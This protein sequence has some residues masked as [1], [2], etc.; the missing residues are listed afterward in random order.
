[1]ARVISAA[2]ASAEN[3]SISIILSMKIFSYGPRQRKSIEA[4]VA[5]AKARKHQQAA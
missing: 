1:M 3:I 5:P 2:A 4:G